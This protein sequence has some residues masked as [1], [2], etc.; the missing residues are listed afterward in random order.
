VK[1]VRLIKRNGIAE[2]HKGRLIQ[3][4]M[5]AML[6][7]LSARTAIHT[8]QTTTIFEAVYSMYTRAGEQYA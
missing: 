7:T 5:S 6:T 8:L 2:C 4:R 1:S 3:E